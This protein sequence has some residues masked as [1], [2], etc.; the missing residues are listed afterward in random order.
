MTVEMSVRFKKALPVGTKLR[1]T[2]RVTADRG[3]LFETAGEI[4]GTDGVIYA[5]AT[6]KYLEAASKVDNL[7]QSFP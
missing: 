4:S 3:R 6:G 1:L 5:T 2:A 7:L